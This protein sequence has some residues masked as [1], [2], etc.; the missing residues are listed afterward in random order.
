MYTEVSRTRRAAGGWGATPMT[1]HD[2]SHLLAWDLARVSGALSE[3]ETT[4]RRARTCRPD[5]PLGLPQRLADTAL[6]LSMDTRSSSAAGRGWT[7]GAAVSLTDQMTALRADIAS[8][9]AMTFASGAP[10]VGD[11]GLWEFLDPALQGA[12]AWFRPA[13]V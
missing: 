12:D 11:A 5:L 13:S 8:A 1:A 6:R 7:P 4:W 10:G 9:R 2:D 3:I